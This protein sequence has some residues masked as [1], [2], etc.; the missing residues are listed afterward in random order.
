MTSSGFMEKVD[1]ALASQIDQFVRENQKSGD[2]IRNAKDALPGGTTRAVLLHQPHPL[3]LQS[4]RDCYVTSL[5][6]REYVDFVSEYCAGMFGHS[7]PELIKTVESVLRSGFTLGGTICEE[8]EFARRLISR[9]PS[10][11]S[12]RFCNSGTEANTFA[13]ATALAYTGRR[14]VCIYLS[15]SKD[16]GLIRQILVFE[17]GYHG[18]TLSFSRGNPMILPHQ[19]IYSTYNDIE[20]TSHKIDIEVGA[21]LVEPMQGAGGMIP[22]SKQ[23]LQFLRSE[24]DR[25]GA[26]LIFDE[27]I[28]SRFFYG[29][30]QEYY[31]ITPDMTT[32]GKH[33]GGGFS[34]G[35]FGGRRPI[36][37][38]FDPQSS[39]YLFHSGTWSNNRFS[40]AAGIKATE[41]LSREAL[42]RTNQLGDR[43]RDG[44]SAV[45]ENKRPG[46]VET[47]G[48]G[49]AI[50]LY[51]P[52]AVGPKLR[53]LYYFY[54]LN[55][56]IY[57]GHRGSL[58]LSLK[59]RE[60][61]VELVLDVTKKFCEE[62]L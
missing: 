48:L 2:A 11:D 9:F 3:V 25:I 33:F 32:I 60:E 50:G 59:H 34:F 36:F 19:F 20:R 24:A 55:N 41:L 18:G 31:N 26:V 37:D 39:R 62:Y 27:V 1:E 45:F 44:I 17:N 28:T 7:H 30:L 42:E 22:A 38:M 5:D 15:A 40:M 16:D 35:A 61:H 23:F 13:L 21:I 47:R 14:K 53:D 29:G 57:S 4:G 54:L 46:V 43:L 8:H 51:F 6:G 12:I 58:V 49:S 56:G 10:M 52:G